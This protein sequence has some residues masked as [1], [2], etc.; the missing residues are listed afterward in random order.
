MRRPSL[1]SPFEFILK[2]LDLDE[3]R[4]LCGPIKFFCTGLIKPCLYC[5][6]F[7][8]WGTVTSQSSR[9]APPELLPQSWKHNIVQNILVCWGIKTAS[10]WRWGTKP[11]PWKTAPHSGLGVLYT[12]ASNTWHWTWWCK[13]WMQLLSHGNPSSATQLLCLH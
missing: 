1:Q 11:K 10:H 6:C 8:H 13:G 5:L 3:V 2:V 4:V 9:K 7:L 12:T